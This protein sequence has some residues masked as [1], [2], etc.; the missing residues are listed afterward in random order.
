MRFAYIDS[1]GNEVPIPSVDALALRI[2]LG[3]ISENT[4]LY[5]AQADQWGP[6]HTHEVFHSLS[7]AAGGDEGFVAPAPVV[8]EPE[9]AAEPEPEPEPEPVAEVELE[10]E[11]A[12]V[13]EPAEPADL[14]LTLA[15]PMDLDL[16]LAEGLDEGLDEEP[17]EEPSEEPSEEPVEDGEGDVD[18]GFGGLD[19]AS[20]PDPIESEGASLDLSAPLDASSDGE[21]TAEE[22]GAES[23]DFGDMGGGLELE[24]SP[25]EPVAAEAM[26]FTGGEMSFDADEPTPDFSGGMELETEMEFDGGD[27]LDLETPMSDFSTEAPPA[28]MEQDGPGSETEEEVLDFSTA[29]AGSEDEGVA[30]EVPL[31]DRRTPVNKPSKPKHRRQR[32]LAGPIVGVVIL[33]AFG[34]GGYVAWPLLSAQLFGPNVPDVPPVVIPD[35]ADGLMPQMRDAADAAFA[36]TFE[37]VRREWAATNPVDAPSRDWLAGIYLAN[38]SD[39]DNVQAFWDGVADFLEGV[40]GIDL[41]TFDAAYQTAVQAEGVTDAD[42]ALLRARA[43][44]G[45][46]AAAPVRAATFDKMEE[47]IE[48]ALAL[49]SFLVANEA[50]IEYVPASNV[51]T[52]PVLEASPSTPEIREAMEDLIDVVTRSLAD[53]GY[54]D[55]VTAEGLWGTVLQQMQE[56]GVQ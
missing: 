13:E 9:P 23:F 44:S 10:P 41:A 34:I 56:N 54:L 6:A 35:L 31:R 30:G 29:G 5:D 2:E 33:L 51:T 17:G 11:P 1:N 28:W 3:A 26:D 46:L 39:F 40:R 50:N 55:L 22:G 25:D 20:T 53:L 45:F 52:D 32:N 47:L 16:D 19:L 24:S 4:E 7:R 36:A 37:D 8:P 27:S 21:D 43:D 38:A 14:G 12:P 18:L 48:G 49:H 42:A 15:D